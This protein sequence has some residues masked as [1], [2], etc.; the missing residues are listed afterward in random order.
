MRKSSLGRTLRYFARTVLCVTALFWFGFAMLSGAENDFEG[1][2]SNLPNTLPWLGFFVV[3]YMAFRWE[4]LGGALVLSAGIAS[5]FFFSAW[6]SPA[7]LLGISLPNIVA[8]AALVACG[9]LDPP[10]RDAGISGWRNKA[11]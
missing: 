10:S 7:V 9:R 6:T 2:L 3:V 5:V 8:G 1:I 4:L 11:P